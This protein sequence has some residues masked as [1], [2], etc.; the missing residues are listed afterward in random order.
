MSDDHFHGHDNKSHDSKRAGE[1]EEH[2]HYHGVDKA[3]EHIRVDQALEMF[4]E[5]IIPVKSEYVEL[6]RA[7]QRVTYEDIRSPMDLP[8]LARST[9]DGYAVNF[10]GDEAPAGSRFSIV[11][12]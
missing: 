11:E 6:A 12:R 1:E 5:Q 7:N 8:R 10:S 4:L 9:R 3:E 2:V